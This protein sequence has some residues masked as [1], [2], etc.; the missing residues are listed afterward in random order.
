MFIICSSCNSKYLVNSADLKPNGRHVQCVKCSHVWFQE[1]AFIAEKVEESSLP[2]LK[3]EQ[4]TKENKKQVNLP[5][6]YVRDKNYSVLN[7]ILVVLLFSSIILS[8]FLIKNHGMNFSV[9]IYFYIQ[10]FYFNLKLIVNDFAKLV[11]Q[12][13]S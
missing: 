13:L 9:L 12:I 2:F 10:E 3:K 6:T 5:S 8:F 7:S 1:A 4:G 11:Y